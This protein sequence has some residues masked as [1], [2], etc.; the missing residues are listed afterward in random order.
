MSALKKNPLSPL[1]KRVVWIGPFGLGAIAALIWMF[2]PQITGIIPVGEPEEQPADALTLTQA[3]FDDLAGWRVDDMQGALRAFQRSC[4]PL[5]KRADDRDFGPDPRMGTIGQWRDVCETALMLDADQITGDA[6]RAFFEAGFTPWLAGNNGKSEG[7]FTG[8]YEP[9]LQGSLTRQG[10]Y[11]TPL[12]ARPDDLIEVNLGDFS[13][14]L[15]GKRIAGRVSGGR[16]QPYHD[17]TAIEGGALAGQD[18][19]LVW[20]D[21]AVAAFFLQIQ[22]SGRVVL[23]DGSILKIGYAATNGHP[24]FAIGRD[25]IERGALTRETVS[26]QTIRAWLSDNPDQAADVMNKNASYVFFTNLPG[27]PDAG[28]L[29]SQGVPLET[30]RS[31]AVDRRFH[32]MGAPVWLETSDAMNA[33]RQFHRLMIAQDT[34]GA[35]RGPVRG[36]IFFG[37]GDEAALYA[38]HMNRQ[39]R[40]FIL[41]PKKLVLATDQRQN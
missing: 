19:E 11:Q 34:G 4:T 5:L 39:G 7:L 15:A 10:D 36:D 9:E 6:A 35:I 17:R 37:P 23:E 27:D 3:G 14:D 25:L 40:K 29:G 28:P 21:D 24:Y 22:G 31:L 16:L 26:L 41:L 38:G 2:W 20:V 33:D 13:S 30:G 18:L 12:Y 8:Y 32:A 1:M